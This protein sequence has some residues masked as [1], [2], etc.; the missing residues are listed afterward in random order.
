MPAEIGAICA[1]LLNTILQ[2]IPEDNQIA[3]DIEEP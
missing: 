1:P 3:L 2:K